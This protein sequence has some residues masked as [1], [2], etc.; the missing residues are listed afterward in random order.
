MNTLCSNIGKISILVMMT[1]I[2]SF[3]AGQSG[4]VDSLSGDGVPEVAA[5][6]DS[7]I[8]I[9]EFRS[10]KTV[11]NVSPPPLI[12]M[13][14]PAAKLSPYLLPTPRYK[15]G[16]T[17]LGY[18]I[19][20]TD[21][22]FSTNVNRNVYY[23]NGKLYLTPYL[24]LEPQKNILELIRENPLRALVYG[25]ATLAGMM[26]NTVMG[27]DKMNKIRLDN[28]VQS[29]TGIPETMISGQGTLHYETDTRKI[30]N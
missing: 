29:R 18:A 2:A 6:T 30:N 14:I 23:N 25:V 21:L 28:M 11:E 7:I 4:T 24:G 16:K 20:W 12:P 3:L 22:N 10:E 19:P 27:E 8:K 1:S 17:A 26:N 13:N 9:P 15:D 5:V